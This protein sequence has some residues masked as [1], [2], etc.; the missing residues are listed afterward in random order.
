MP[1][2]HADLA[3]GVDDRLGLQPGGGQDLPIARQIGGGQAHEGKAF[4]AVE[5]I[6]D[7]LAKMCRRPID[8]AQQL[9]IGVVELEDPV[10]G[11]DLDMAHLRHDLEAEALILRARHFHILGRDHEMIERTSFGHRSAPWLA[12]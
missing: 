10:A 6:D 11:S 4:A 2:G 1:F 8:I 12:Q 5:A 9:D 3:P 7:L